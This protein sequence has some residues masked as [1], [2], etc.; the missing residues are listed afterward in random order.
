MSMARI[1]TSLRSI[2]STQPSLLDPLAL[3]PP[4]GARTLHSHGARRRRGLCCGRELLLHLRRTGVSSRGGRMGRRCGSICW[5]KF[6]ASPASSAQPPAWA[7]RGG[8]HICWIDR[9]G[10]EIPARHVR[11]SVRGTDRHETRQTARGAYS[12]YQFFY[13]LYSN[14]YCFLLPQSDQKNK[15]F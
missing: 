12:F 9:D 10:C 1:P 8:W 6:S 13:Q 2:S 14:I 15:Q 5:W 7:P 11:G 4:A 3:W